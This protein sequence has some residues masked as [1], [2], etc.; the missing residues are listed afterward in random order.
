[1]FQSSSLP[2]LQVIFS[3]YPVDG[4]M[5]SSE[6]LELAQ[7]SQQ[8]CANLKSRKSASNAV[9]DFCMKVVT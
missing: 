3:K 8:R 9:D 2:H 7:A 5:K 6:I 4:S 1:M